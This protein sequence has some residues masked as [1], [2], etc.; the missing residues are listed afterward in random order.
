MRKRGSVLCRERNREWS[1][2]RGRGPCILHP[3][4]HPPMYVCE[5]IYHV[6]IC[7]VKPFLYVFSPSFLHHIFFVLRKLRTY[8]MTHAHTHKQANRSLARIICIRKHVHVH[9]IIHMAKSRMNTSEKWILTLKIPQMSLN[10][11]IGM[12]NFSQ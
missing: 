2:E 6:L 12:Q 1:R 11:V 9:L 4:T 8:E 7:T 5:S 3:P 10:L